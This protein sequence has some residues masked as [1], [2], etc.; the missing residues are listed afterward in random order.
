MF[1]I[2]MSE[3]IDVLCL[4]LCAAGTGESHHARLRTRGWR[5]YNTIIPIVTQCLNC[6]ALFVPTTRA[7]GNF[8]TRV[9]A[10]R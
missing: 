7:G 5:R 1:Y 3:D 9:H 10:S 4:C 8:Y 2:I 6:A